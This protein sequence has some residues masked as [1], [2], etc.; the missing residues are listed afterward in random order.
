[1]ADECESTEPRDPLIIKFMTIESEIYDLIVLGGGSAGYAAARTAHELNKTVAVVDGSEELS[2]LCI[3]RGCMPSKTLIYSAEV[4]HLA[5]QGKLFGFKG[6]EPFADLAAMQL[7]KRNVIKE[8][9]DYRK[10][11]L[12]DGRFSLFRQK[13]YLS[14]PHTIRL[15]DGTEL[16]TEKILIST[17]SL[18]N[19]PD[20][21]GLVKSPFKTSDDVLNLDTL[22]EECVVLGGGIVACELAQFLARVGCRVTQL[23]RSSQVLKEFSNDAGTVVGQALRDNGINLQT[24]TQLQSFEPLGGDRVRVNYDWEGKSLSIETNFLFHALGRA[25]ATSNLGL[26]E[27]GVKL[28]RSGHIST[29][30]FQQTSLDHIYAAGDCAGPHEIVH[31]AI[32]QGENAVLHAF[33]KEVEPIHYD[34]LLG[35]VF[36]DPQV[37]RVGLS[38]DQIRER[39]IDP[40]SASFPFDDHGKSILMEAKYGYVAVHATRTTGVILGAECVSKDAGELIHSLSVAVA[41]KA[42]VND[43]LKADWYHPTLSEIWTYPL[44]DIAEEIGAE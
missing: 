21:P 15:E 37:A 20:L 22:P 35:V 18:I 30:S 5:Q 28:S 29:D 16:N 4:L 8:F 24:E 7:R 36:T 31:I 11:Q 23:Q 14:G 17:G 25:P 40:V 32:K 3:L 34:Y 33:G 13:G 6:S 39:G 10:Q 2:G 44:E 12:E 27:N 42:T 9:S 1:M 26:E 38:P 19:T 41:L 43:L